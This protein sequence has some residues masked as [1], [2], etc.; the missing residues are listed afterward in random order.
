M[1]ASFFAR[2]LAAFP[3]S[4]FCERLWG[5]RLPLQATGYQLVL[6]E[7]PSSGLS[8][9]EGIAMWEPRHDTN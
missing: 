2:V 3:P 6:K 4:L 1:S 8:T 5:G 7:I 9:M